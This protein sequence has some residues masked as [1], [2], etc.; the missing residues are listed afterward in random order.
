MSTS[1]SGSNRWRP[2]GRVLRYIGICA[3]AAVFM[4][5]QALPLLA[6][7]GAEATP[8]RANLVTPT[9]ENAGAFA[10]TITASFTPSPL[11]AARLQALQS[12]GNVNVRA[13]PD[14]ESDLI[15]T[16]AHGSVYP[17]LRNY[18]R[19]YELRY[20]LS[21]NGRAWVYGDLVTIEG[22]TSRIEVI[23]TFD[24]L[25]LPGGAAGPSTDAS[26]TNPRTIEIAT[27]EFDAARAV[28]V[29]DVTPLPTFTP[30]A[31]QPPFVNQIAIV[32]AEESRLLDLPPIIPILALGGLG[33]AGLFISL[34]RR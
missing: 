4:L 32:E 5:A 8:V 29:V 19:W 24:Q 1:Y 22:D 6:Q 12:A 27:A 25:A 14:I 33:L 20:D 15:G 3:L 10:P 2:A 18:Y 23:E 17:V 30:P 9:P 13:L 16:I 11:P 7:G 26:G 34:L 21:P 31:T 28:E